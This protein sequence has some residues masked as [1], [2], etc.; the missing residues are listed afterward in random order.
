MGFGE[1]EL[2]IYRLVAVD[3]DDTLLRPDGTVSPR[4]LQAVRRL[5]EEGIMVVLAS[6]RMHEDTAK[7]YPLLGISGPV[8][9]YN[10][11]MVRDSDG[12]TTYQHLTVPAEHAAEIVRF[13]RRYGYHVNYYLNDVLYVSE[14]TYWSDLYCSR[15]GSTVREVGDLAQFEGSEP[16]KLIILNTPEETDRL[17]RMFQERYGADLYI[18]KTKPEYL[19]FMNKRASKAEG[20][21]VIGEAFGIPAGEMAAIGDSYNDVSML[22]YAGLGIA[23][24]DGVPEVLAV[25]DA[26]AP[27]CADDGFAA[28]VEKLILC[29]ERKFRQTK[30]D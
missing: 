24:G 16:T 17:L 29:S 13:A 20:L 3:L 11:A 2:M 25:A 26:V 23:M 1:S 8:I 5:T 12:S 30:G 21:R 4:N 10:G 6:G 22:E 19:E 18:T 7:Y 14:R 15:T 28:A 27:P 9:S